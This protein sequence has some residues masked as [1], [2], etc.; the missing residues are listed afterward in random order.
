[1]SSTQTETPAATK[2]I[3]LTREQR[4][5]QLLDVAW[6]LARE[7][8]TDAL[9]LPRLAEEAGVAK[10]VVYDHF[11]TRNGLLAALYQDFDVDQT[12]MIDAA[13]AGSGSD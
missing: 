9:T 13:I 8:G 6:R 4:L 2:R 7:E 11:S 3:R 10:P 12:A 1:M 5:R